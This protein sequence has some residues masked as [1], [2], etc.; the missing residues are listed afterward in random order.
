M[1]MEAAINSSD[2]VAS[3]QWLNKTGITSDVNTATT[4][5]TAKQSICNDNDGASGSK[6][7]SRGKILKQRFERPATLSLAASVNERR[8]FALTVARPP[9]GGLGCLALA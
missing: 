3:S 9:I 4:Q 6:S 5:T 8:S 2:A 1:A 7:I